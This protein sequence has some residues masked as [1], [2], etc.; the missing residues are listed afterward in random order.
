MVQWRPLPAR[1]AL[2]HCGRGLKQVL[3]LPCLLS[4]REACK[5][6]RCIPAPPVAD[7]CGCMPAGLHRQCLFGG[8]R[9]GLYEPVKRLY[10]GK[11][12][13]GPAPFYKKVLKCAS[14]S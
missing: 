12:P 10:M 8:L 14:A 2:A 6:V 1:R 7:A 11:N 4:M 3:L 9:I 5:A 13:D